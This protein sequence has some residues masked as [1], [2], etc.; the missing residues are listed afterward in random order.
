MKVVHIGL[1]IVVG[2]LSVPA[3]GLWQ[4]TH[5]KPVPV[6]TLPELSQVSG[7]TFPP[8]TTILDAGSVDEAGTM[9][10]MVYCYA[11]VSMPR[12]SVSR[13][14][15]HQSQAMSLRM[16]NPRNAASAQADIIGVQ[17]SLGFR[18]DE[19]KVA[20]VKHYEAAYVYGVG[21]NVFIDLDNPSVARVYISEGN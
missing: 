10:P 16:R 13:F 17:K 20:D 15:K 2:L 1:V 19:W 21:G 7:L 14:L 5:P 12:G 6:L 4:I 8:Q 18:S 11:V 3:V 9:Y